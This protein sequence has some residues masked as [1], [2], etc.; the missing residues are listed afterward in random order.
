MV[1][2]LLT[3]LFI[4]YFHVRTQKI[5]EHV[6]SIRTLVVQFKANT[7]VIRLP[8][9]LF[10]CARLTLRNSVFIFMFSYVYTYFAFSQTK[11]VFELHAG[12]SLLN[13]RKRILQ[14]QYPSLGHHKASMHK[15]GDLTCMLLDSKQF[16]IQDRKRV[17]ATLEVI[18]PGTSQFSGCRF[19]PQKKEPRFKAETEP[20]LN[21][22]TN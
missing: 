20:T 12:W 19:P 11:T 7:W 1:I 22:S 16:F 2:L 21:C 17:G 9:L 14:T 13:I 4:Y 8:T 5:V 3:F 15:P 10:G 6:E 18:F